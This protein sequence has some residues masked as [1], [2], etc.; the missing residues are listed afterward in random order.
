MRSLSSELSLGKSYPFLFPIYTILQTTKDASLSLSAS[1]RKALLKTPRNRG[2][3]QLLEPR[4]SCWL[5]VAC[6]HSPSHLAFCVLSWH[7]SAL[8]IF[9]PRNARGPKSMVQRT[10]GIPAVVWYQSEVPSFKLLR[11]LLRV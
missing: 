5:W 7:F 1:I 10:F 3:K 9:C 11:T 4:A 2:W 6:I 8:A